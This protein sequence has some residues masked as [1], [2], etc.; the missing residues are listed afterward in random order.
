MLGNREDLRLE[1]TALTPRFGFASASVRVT[2]GEMYNYDGSTVDLKASRRPDTEDLRTTYL[3]GALGSGYQKLGRHAA[4][5]GTGGSVSTGL[6][7]QRPATAFLD[8]GPRI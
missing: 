8:L 4:D 6:D 5:P 7:Q 3:F 2:V 1:H